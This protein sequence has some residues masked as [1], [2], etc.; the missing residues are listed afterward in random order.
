MDEAKMVI[1]KIIGKLQATPVNKRVDT[2]PYEWFE[3]NHR[4]L[5]R[6]ASSGEEIRLRLLEPLCDG[7][8]LFEDEEKVIVLSLTPCELTRV[9]V[10]SKR[11][12]GRLCWEM[13][14]RHLPLAIDEEGICTPYDQPTFAYLQ[15]LGFHCERVTAKF[16]PESSVRGH[17]HG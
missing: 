5:K 16:T 13:G 15:K 14:N 2:V 9:N 17:G 6:T 3:Q 11:E 1:E 10:A 12:M 4:I 8:I 7:G